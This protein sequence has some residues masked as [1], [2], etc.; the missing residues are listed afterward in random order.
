VL[1]FRAAPNQCV[2]GDKVVRV[3][4]LSRCATGG[5]FDFDS[6]IGN[7][8]SGRVTG[9]PAFDEHMNFRVAD[10]LVCKGPGLELTSCSPPR[11][12]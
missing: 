3:P 2:A 7:C 5:V 12:A 4:H 9:G 8:M 11:H 1:N 6:F 10:P